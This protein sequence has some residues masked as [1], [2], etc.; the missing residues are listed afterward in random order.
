MAI[1]YRLFILTFDSELSFD[2]VSAWAVEPTAIH[3]L[4]YFTLHIRDHPQGH[5]FHHL[6]RWRISLVVEDLDVTG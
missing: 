2:I 1:W 3:F 6:G 5:E 4:D